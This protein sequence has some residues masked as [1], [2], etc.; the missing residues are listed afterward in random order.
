MG[1]TAQQVMDEA[2]RY[3][4]QEE[5]ISAGDTAFMAKITKQDYIDVEFRVIEETPLLLS[6]AQAPKP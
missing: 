1:L 5:R 6:P 4:A 3:L 2:R